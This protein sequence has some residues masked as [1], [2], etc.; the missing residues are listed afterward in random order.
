MSAEI[1]G[2]VMLAF[3]GE[4][5]PPAIAAR[6]RDAPAAGMTLFRFVNVHTPA[7]V[8][9]LTDAFQ[10][11][12]AALPQAAPA[13]LL[14]A[15]DQEGGQLQALGDGPTAFSGNLALGA[16][17]DEGLTERV[18]RAIGTEAR[19]MGVNVVYAPV[20]DVATEPANVALGIRS[21]GD[22][23]VAVARHGAAMIRGLQAAGVAATAKHFP[24]LGDVASDT[25]HGG[26]AVDG[27]RDRLDRVELAPF[28]AGI[29]AGARLVM[30]AH[31][32]ARALTGDATLPATL[33]R[34]VMTDLLRGELGFSG[35]TISDA[36][37]MGALAQGAAQA[38][39]VVAAV[40]AGVDLLLCAPDP[41]ARARIEATLVA[42]AG[43][44]V[45]DPH[46]LD[47]SLA[48][49]R[50]LRSWVRAAGPIP[51]LDV[52]GCAAHRAIARELAERALTLV[53]DDA[54]VL[55]LRLP[56]DAAILAVMPTPT[57][58]TPADTS[59]V[60]PP[61]LAGALRAL[62]PQVDE[63]VVP[64]APS[65]ADIAAA[66]S[67]ADAA[68]AIV[69]GT[70]DGAREP[71]QLALVRALAATGRP[72]VAVALRTPWD[73]AAYPPAVAAVCTYSIHPAALE[74]LAAA[75]LGHA[76]ERRPSEG[77]ARDGRP[78]ERA[79]PGRLPVTVAGAVPAAGAVPVA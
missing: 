63:L 51:S 22:D 50:A 31:V 73:V 17:D 62:H 3:E 72:T 70:L 39:D 7:Q 41:Q 1:L 6:L 59:S 13:P 33:S 11:S 76:G 23:P 66:V 15:A 9:E 35:V 18:G 45:I 67:R 38:V 44:R 48:R 46:E 55:P 2:R 64:T 4:R 5:L 52:V 43:R 26:V 71:G 77:S 56:A 68:D 37:D 25:H 40:L 53:R 30:S 47:D 8:R 28:R 16:V 24:G 61:G 36:L 75:V 42:A 32:A 69:V 54:G 65:D 20:L 57:D 34:A 49:V 27:S 12:G 14:V 21:F 10:S 74:A 79:F 60:V 29:A 58:L 78:G 19:A